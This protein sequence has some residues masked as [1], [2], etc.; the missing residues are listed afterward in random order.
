[1]RILKRAEEAKKERI[2]KALNKIEVKAPEEP[3][4]KARR[5]KKNV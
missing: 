3:K 1:M 5:T 4:K 2:E